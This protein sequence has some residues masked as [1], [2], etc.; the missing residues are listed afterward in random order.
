MSPALWRWWIQ[1]ML[2]RYTLLLSK[3]EV[4]SSLVVVSFL[5][6]QGCSQGNM[7][8][9]VMYNS[10]GLRD[11]FSLKRSYAQTPWKEILKNPATCPTSQYLCKF[12]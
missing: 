6:W 7:Y 5:L 10:W 1:D 9:L 8:P 2:S 12:R 11:W 4:Q 3:H